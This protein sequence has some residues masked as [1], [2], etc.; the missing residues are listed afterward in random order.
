M[1][2]KEKKIDVNSV[3]ISSTSYKKFTCKYLGVL[4]LDGCSWNAL[5]NHVVAKATAAQNYIE[6]NFKM[7]K[8]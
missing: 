1:L 3:I 5:A 6:K 4:L 2:Y 8:F 7:Y